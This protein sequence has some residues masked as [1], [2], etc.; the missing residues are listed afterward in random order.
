MSITDVHPHRYN[1][2]QGYANRNGDV[3]NRF[4][5]IAKRAHRSKLEGMMSVSM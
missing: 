4:D 5:L 2:H 1:R 3:K